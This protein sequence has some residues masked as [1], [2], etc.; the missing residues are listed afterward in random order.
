MSMTLC[1]TT[2]MT[3]YIMQNFVWNSASLCT[4]KNGSIL[5]L[6]LPSFGGRM[7]CAFILEKSRSLYQVTR[8]LKTWRNFPR[9]LKDLKYGKSLQSLPVI[10]NSEKTLKTWLKRFFQYGQLKSQQHLWECFKDDWRI[11]RIKKWR[12]LPIREATWS[13]SFASG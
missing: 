4:E 1:F 2:S 5:P 9:K 12:R 10:G 3:L 8:K 13:C 6:F 11:P 7:V